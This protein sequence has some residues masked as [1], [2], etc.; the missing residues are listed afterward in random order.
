ML[1]VSES[2]SLSNLSNRRNPQ[3]IAYF[4]YLTDIISI[5]WQF[6]KEMIKNGNLPFAVDERKSDTEKNLISFEA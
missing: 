4:Q 1:K 3:A 6:H 5:F 2:P